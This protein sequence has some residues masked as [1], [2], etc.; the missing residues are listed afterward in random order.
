MAKVLV[1]GATGFIGRHLCRCLLDF[2][3]LVRGSYRTARPSAGYD[4]N[5]EWI[6]V[7]EIGPGTCWSKALDGVSYVVHAAGMAHQIGVPDHQLKQQFESVNAEGTRRLAHEV[8]GAPWIKRF[9]FIST[10]KVTAEASEYS[11]SKKFAEQ[12]LQE[13]LS[14]SATDWCILRP[15]MVYGTGNPGNMARLIRLIRTGLP[16]PL[17]A[18]RNERS[19]IFVGNLSSAIE[20]C[21][22]HPN[23]AGQIFAVSDGPPLS[24]PELIRELSRHAD[25]P[26]RLLFVPVPILLGMARVG[27]VVKMAT[28]ISCGW[29]SYSADRLCKSY[30]VDCSAIRSKLQWSPPFSMDEGLR[31]TMQS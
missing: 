25:R 15:P 20:R 21:L 19:F 8:A 30:A 4:P 3:Y 23:A 26:A 12:A 5:I 29:D 1:T 27:D 16:L 2:G 14:T 28:G 9:I 17:G 10:V 31:I 13:E 22:S 24:T 11:C 18:I 7:G 6:E